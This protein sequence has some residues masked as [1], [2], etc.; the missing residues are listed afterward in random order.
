MRF[1]GLV[2]SGGGDAGLDEGASGQRGL[3]QGETELP[4]MRGKN[5][6]L[7][8][9]YGIPMSMRGESKS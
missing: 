9:R 2:R 1:G 4:E 6:V 5:R 8:L 3:G 7:Q